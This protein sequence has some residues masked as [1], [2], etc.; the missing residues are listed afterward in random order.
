[1]SA[2]Y[3]VNLILKTHRDDELLK[4][5]RDYMNSAQYVNF[6]GAQNELYSVDDM[7]K[8]FLAAHQEDFHSYGDGSYDSAFN[9]SYGWESVLLDWW[10]VMQPYLDEGSKMTVWPDSGKWE[11]MVF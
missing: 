9:A 7:V 4:T 1:M 10:L 11:V 2:C 5:V 6:H 3:A 8:V